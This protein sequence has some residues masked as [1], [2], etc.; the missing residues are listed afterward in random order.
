MISPEDR[1]LLFRHF[2]EDPYTHLFH[3][4]DLDERAEYIQWFVRKKGREIGAV[5]LLFQ[6]PEIP[7]FQLLEQDNPEAVALLEEILPQLPDK[8]YCHLSDGPAEML[9]RHY[10][11]ESK[12]RFMK[13]RWTKSVKKVT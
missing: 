13:M 10:Q 4:A 11:T 3:L 2:M 1:D 7:V 5:A 8:L 9:G 12:H 6:K